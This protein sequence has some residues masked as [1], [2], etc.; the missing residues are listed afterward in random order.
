MVDGILEIRR[1]EG[2]DGSIARSIRMV[3]INGIHHKP[4]WI[5]FN[6]TDDGGL[7]FGDQST[8]F[9]KLHNVRKTN[10]RN[11]NTGF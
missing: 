10:F 2:K 11:T 3:S 5:Q 1:E 6:I 4:A 9:I 8:D 7:V